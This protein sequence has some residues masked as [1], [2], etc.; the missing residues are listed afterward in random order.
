MR[1]KAEK[2]TDGALRVLVQLFLHVAA[3]VKAR[4]GMG[5]ADALEVGVA[6]PELVLD[7]LEPH[8]GAHPRDEL[9]GLGG[10]VR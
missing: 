8:G 1:N 6:A 3:V 10:L 4:Q 2:V 5:A 9:G 7:A